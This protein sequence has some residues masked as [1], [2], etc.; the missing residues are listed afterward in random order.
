MAGGI[1]KLEYLVVWAILVGSAT[2]APSAESAA[3][4]SNH[5]AFQPITRPPVPNVAAQALVR[6]PVDGFVLDQLEAA[7][8]SLAPRAD[9]RTLVRRLAL[10]V[11][12]LPPNKRIVDE[13]VAD[14]AP[15]AYERVVEKLLASPHYGE[16]WARHWLDVARFAESSGY[17]E[18]HNWPHFWRYRDWVVRSFNEDKPFD[19]FL[20]QQLAGDELEPYADENIVATG[21]LAAAR[22]ATE[23]L[24]CVRQENDLYVDIV[25]TVSSA[26]MGL[27]MGC[28][29][30]HDHMFDP[31][32]ERDYYR[33]QAF[34][35]RG[36]PGNL[37][38]RSSQV[39]DEFHELT[40]KLTA[41]DLA[42]RGR[43]L[44]AA[45][46]EQ[47]EHERRVLSASPAD[48][49]AEEESLYRIRRAELNIRVAGC[50]AFRIHD[51][52]KQKLE[53]LRSELAEFDDKIVQ[54][55]GF[56]SPVTSPHQISVLPMAGNF[57]LLHD[58]EL[59][60]ARPCYLLHRGD[61]YQTLE[62]V[63]PGFPAVLDA[64]ETPV[65]S[66]RPRTAL[67][68]WLTD[69]QH[70]LTARVWVNRIWSY[71][72][73]HGI[74]A[75]PGN[76]GTRGAAPTH[77]DLL[78]YLASELIESGWSTKHVQRL[79][80]KS[81]TYRQSALYDEA[82][83][84]ID[85]ENRLFWCWPR[86]RLEAEAIRDAM[87][88]VAGQLDEQLG[89]PSVAPDTPTQ[90]RSLYLLQRR[91]QPHTVAQLFDGP[92]EMSASCAVRQVSTSA[93]QPLFLL[94]NPVVVALAEKLA[95]S[96]ADV[97]SNDRERQVAM[98]FD[99][100][101]SRLP[102]HEEQT[103]AAAYLREAQHESAT[104]DRQT[105][106]AA[107]LVSD[108]ETPISPLGRLCQAMMNLNEF[109]YVP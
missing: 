27:T 9:R 25:N 108:E 92:T 41:T 44:G 23:E 74:V 61:P 93:V 37:V 43:I 26:F 107:E 98:V 54:T 13:F 97:A 94:N 95:A 75:T 88:A 16:R 84:S 86:R 5:W 109:I 39:P 20:T 83:A 64:D 45:Y 1:C 3:P 28:A 56:C 31:L 33:L 29:Q 91:D 103:V 73:G 106:P 14:Q 18:N 90:R 19:V 51:E 63:V 60:T 42:V 34:F 65:S 105:S 96:I 24:S 67:A 55:R 10:N 79:I 52:E 100:V 6:T 62:R 15:G 85:P 71:H 82:S 38:L 57:P 59:L 11:L 58:V 70:P 47:P 89:G 2:T 48:R 50:N 21:F 104:V 99:R 101:L 7:G 30:C 17:V 80:L 49:S 77:P 81:N 87:L 12:G 22:L 35:T 72:F 66:D 76:F 32:T 4:P 40:R 53:R 46:D 69:R 68:A 8:L 36:Y 78:D 102:T